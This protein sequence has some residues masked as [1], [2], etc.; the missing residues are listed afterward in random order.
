MNL[1]I[2]DFSEEDG[3]FVIQT[4]VVHFSEVKK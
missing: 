3:K 2:N 4:D 1:P